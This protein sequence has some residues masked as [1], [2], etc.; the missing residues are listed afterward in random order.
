MI[1]GENFGS[2][3]QQKYADTINK[4]V[5]YIKALD[6]GYFMVDTDLGTFKQVP[7]KQLQN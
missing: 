6:I 1:D 3:K 4:D 7:N 5:W 2:D